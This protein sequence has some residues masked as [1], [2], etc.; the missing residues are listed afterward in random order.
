[1]EPIM[2]SIGEFAQWSGLT[3]KALRLY[4][5][6]GILAPAEVD[7][8][9]GY[10]RYAAGQLRDAMMIKALR[11]AGVPLPEVGAALAAPDRAGELLRRHRERVLAARAAEDEAAERSHKVLDQL[12]AEVRV[13][14]RSA[15]AQ[16]YA[17]LV[18]ELSATEEPDL[19]DDE[20][21]AGFGALWTALTES[22]NPP[23]GR[24]W[25][26]LRSAKDPEQVELML[27]WPV[28]REPDAGFAVNGH[29]IEIGTLPEREEIVA[30]WLHHGAVEPAAEVMHPAAVALIDAIARRPETGDRDLDFGGGLLRQQSITD[31]GGKPIGIELA[32][33]IWS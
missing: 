31:D 29:R 5:E 26:T 4:D 10:R 1:M 3:V 11:D 15:P 18:V 25:S 7:P 27:C 21:D 22:G 9:S 2:L 6:R 12:E 33:V 19:E 14:R 24:F 32:Y 17:G 16:P 28:A 13:T 23:T 30:G 8:H 20:A